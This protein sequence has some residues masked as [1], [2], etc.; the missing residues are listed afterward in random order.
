MSAEGRAIE[1]IGFWDQGESNTGDSVATYEAHLLEYQGDLTADNGSNVPVLL[2]QTSAAASSSGPTSAQLKVALENPT[3]F[4]LACAKYH[5]PYQDDAHLNSQGVARYGFYLGRALDLRDKGVTYPFIYCTSAVKTG[6]K[7]LLTFHLPVAGTQL[8]ED[9][10]LVT[11]PGGSYPKGMSYTDDSG[12]N[13]CT[14]AAVVGPNQIEL[15]LASAATSTNKRVGIA[16]NPWTV[17]PLTGNNAAGP[18]YGSRCCFRDNNDEVI[19]LGVNRYPAYNWPVHQYI[20]V[21]GS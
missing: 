13:S 9:T 4:I 20:D 12:I 6:N 21:T 5:F 16:M 15:T 18:V 17:N 2:G 10:T 7:V 19:A 1:L 11:N 3:K 8:V 14:A